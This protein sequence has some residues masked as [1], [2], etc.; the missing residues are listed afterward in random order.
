MMRNPKRR[1]WGAAIAGLVL[2]A[3]FSSCAGEKAR[4]AFSPSASVSDGAGQRENTLADGTK[5]DIA[6]PDE[7]TRDK[8]S[9]RS[10]VD[11]GAEEGVIKLRKRGEEDGMAFSLTESEKERVETILSLHEADARKSDRI[12]PP[13]TGYE[14]VTRKDGREDK[15]IFDVNWLLSVRER[16]GEGAEQITLSDAEQEELSSLAKSLFG[17][18]ETGTIR[19]R[20][21]DDGAVTGTNERGRETGDPDQIGQRMRMNRRF[22][23]EEEPFAVYLT[24]E[25]EARVRSILAAHRDE[26]IVSASLEEPMFEYSVDWREETLS[27][28]AGGD[29]SLHFWGSDRLLTV[30]GYG[31]GTCLCAELSEE[32]HATLLEIAEACFGKG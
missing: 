24:D 17:V 8:T 25:E 18:G 27:R 22:D 32:E 3:F 14:L 21:N 11:P 5:G 31:R 4:D 6:A 12:D 20:E 15:L 1:L 29:T 30:S 9:E 23:G 16:E 26:L 7:D 10:P 19:G 13:H 28:F 2:L